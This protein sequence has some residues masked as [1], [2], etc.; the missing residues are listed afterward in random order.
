[1]VLPKNGVPDYSD[2]WG[3]GI[4]LNF[5]PAGDGGTAGYADLSAYAGIE[6]DFSGTLIPFQSMRVDF[7]FMGQ[8]GATRRTGWATSTTPRHSRLATS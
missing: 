5:N 4:G 1:M 8:H 3:G 6:F 2:L 7:P